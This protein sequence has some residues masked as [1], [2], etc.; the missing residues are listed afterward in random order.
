MSLAWLLTNLVA[1]M[2]LPPLNGLVLMLLGYGLANRRPRWARACTVLGLL[3]VVV[4]AL[5]AVGYALVR[6]LEVAPVSA[7]DLRQAQAIVVLGGGRYRAALEYGDDTVSE[8][9]LVRLRYAAKLQRQTGLPVL[10]TGG[11]PDGGDRSEAAA[12]RQVLTEEFRVPVRWTE[13]A[14]DNTY[15]NA[16]G[17]AHILKSEGIQ[18]VA[19]V[20]HSWHMSRAVQVFTA[21]G[22][23]VIPAPTR[24]YREPTTLLDWLPGRYLES[25]YAIH[26]W[27]GRVWYWLRG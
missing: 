25:R 20:T 15:E 4:L 1:A 7:A 18:R 14:S 17:S 10:V 6:T 26:E 22:L 12:M 13:D 16:M 19:L 23:S 3:L 8:T 9:T 21:A 2:L 27:I 5:P 11:K 24:F